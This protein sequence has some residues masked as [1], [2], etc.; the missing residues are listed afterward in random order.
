MMRLP[1]HGKTAPHAILD[2]LRGCNCRCV[3]CYNSCQP[4]FKSLEQLKQEMQVVLRARNVSTITL[5]GGEPLLH[6]QLHEIINWLHDD[7]KLTVCSLS[8]GI[9]FDDEMAQ[10]MRDAGCSLITLHIQEGQ[11]RPDTSHCSI[12]D[13]RRSK[14]KI[15]RK[16][17]L[18]PA[19]ILTIEGE[20][21]DSFRKLALFLRQSPEF[22]YALVTIARDFSKISPD[23][24]QE[25]VQRQP[26]LD[27]LCQ[28]G[29]SPAAFVGGHH[30]PDIPRWYVF[31]SVQALDDNGLEQAWNKT[32]PGLLERAFLY[33]YAFFFKRSIHW[34]QTTSAKLKLRLLLNGLTGGHFSTSL[35]A[36]KSIIHGWTLQE[37]HIVVQLPP[38]SL[39]NGQVEFCDSCPDASVRNGK[40]NPLCLNDV[41]VD[42]ASQE[43]EML[44]A[45]P[46]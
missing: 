33:G 6:P 27:A 11:I 20:D 1:W 31:Q 42:H 2:I 45:S 21:S 23:I 14:G 40:L 12:D 29:Y 22:E 44:T 17:G 26:M 38:Y 32:R 7:L 24:P 46:R 25:D 43:L 39:G 3:N 4:T 30:H 37:K 19:L 9:L 8:N 41:N 13:L 15:A 28:G 16:H 34:I 35:F 18:F 36:L 5:S 10:K